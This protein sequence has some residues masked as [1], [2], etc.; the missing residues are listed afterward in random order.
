MRSHAL[1]SLLALA[2]GILSVG[3]LGALTVDDAVKQARDHN[4]GLETEA[5]KVAQKADEKNFSFNRLYPTI[6]TNA[7][8]LH[9]NNLN[10]AQTAGLW[11]GIFGTLAKQ[12]KATFVSSSV[13]TSQMTDDNNWNAALGVN[14]QFLWSVAAFRG[15]AQTLI[16]YDN[17]VLTRTAATAK[18]DRDVR[19]AF[20]Q[21]LALHEATGVLESQLKVAEDRYKLAKL[22]FEAGLGSEMAMLQAEV[23]LENRKPAVADQRLN[24]QNAQAAFRILLNL[25]E[26]APLNLEGTLAVS[27]AD[28]QTGSAL[29]PDAL[30]RGR[31]QGRWDVATARGAV[32][33]L[34]NLADL[35]ADTLLPA[36]VFGWSADPTVNAPFKDGRW[37]TWSNYA[38]SSG[39][40][41]VGLGWKLDGLLPG[42]TTGL[43]IAGLRRQAQQAQLG[44]E[45]TLRGGE[46]E[47]RA[48][49]GKVKKSATS[50]EGLSLAL[51]LA[52]R[53]SKLTEASYQAGNS[54]FN[55]AQDADLQLQTARL[56]YLNEEL[57]FTS[58]L[59]DLD[60]AL[61]ADR[62]QWF[63]A[64]HG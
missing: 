56:Q 52:Q 31:L 33:S 35:Q 4:L 58:T 50:L 48:L 10:M 55:D 24:E 6:S 21:L 61:A 25:P 9:L 26:G 32:R 27:D 19:K 5:L 41:M 57:N 8:V 14:V 53:S 23:A 43:S 42:S 30:V 7:T 12:G 49:V 16:D 2:T 3:G 1:F 29:D 59:A 60:Y 37:Q 46:A 62:S 17:A 54:S 64:V 28:R 51:N 11:D 47:I 63:G 18:L 13:L 15:I 44:V 34:G 22:N 36:L 38:Q 39:N 45:Q 40:F 20:Y